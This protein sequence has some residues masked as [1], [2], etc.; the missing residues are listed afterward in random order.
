MPIKGMI[1]SAELD[2]LGPR[3]G[4]HQ[5]GLGGGEPYGSGLS[6]RQALATWTAGLAR[7]GPDVWPDPR[8]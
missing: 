1:W 8:R 6:Y 7:P 5:S 3:L 4:G 2:K